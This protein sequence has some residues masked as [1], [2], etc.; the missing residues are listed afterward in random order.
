MASTWMVKRIAFSVFVA[1]LCKRLVL[2]FG[3]V[4]LYQRLK[5]FFV[6]L[7]VGFFVG[8]FLSFGVD[9]VWFKG[10][11]HPVLHG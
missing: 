9:V 6:G 2:R 10:G 4:A 7:A 3:G 8:V 5:P 11:G 1:W